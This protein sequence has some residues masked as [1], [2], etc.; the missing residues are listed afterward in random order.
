[1]EYKIEVGLR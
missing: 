1:M